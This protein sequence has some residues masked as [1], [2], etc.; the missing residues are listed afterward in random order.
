MGRQGSAV[1]DEGGGIGA[2]DVSQVRMVG[3]CCCCGELVVCAWTAAA[4][5]AVAG[6]AAAVAG[7][8]AAWSVLAAAGEETKR[9]KQAMGERDQLARLLCYVFA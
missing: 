3:R 9:A 6:D 8:A 1:G 2:S 5:S 4:A 7:D